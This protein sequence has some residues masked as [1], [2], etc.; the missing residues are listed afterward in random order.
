M[1]TLGRLFASLI[2]TLLLAQMALSC[3]APQ[4]IYGRASLSIKS[5]PGI[6][7]SVSKAS[8]VITGHDHPTP[9]GTTYTSAF[10]YYRLDGFLPCGSYDVH[11]SHKW[12]EFDSEIV[13][14]HP[15]DFPKG[16]EGVE[17]NFRSVR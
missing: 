6:Q 4:P 16:N 1:K 5:F 8:V 14:I 11:I 17:V 9:F 2:C 3:G 15:I 10:G 12:Y 13:T 7:F